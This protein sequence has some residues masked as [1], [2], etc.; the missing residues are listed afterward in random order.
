MN[1]ANLS[2]DFLRNQNSFTLPLYNEIQI[3][4]IHIKKRKVYF[5]KFIYRKK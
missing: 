3:Y 2:Y 1:R 4:N 5:E